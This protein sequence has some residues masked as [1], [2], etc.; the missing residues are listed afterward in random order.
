MKKCPNCGGVV[1]DEA[2]HCQCGH[3]FYVREKPKRAPQSGNTPARARKWDRGLFVIVALFL[4]VTFIRRL[5]PIEEMPR[6]SEIVLG[7]LIDLA[8]AVALVGLGTRI[9]KAIPRGTPGRGGWLSLFVTGLISLLG[10]FVIHLNG[11]QRVEWQPRRPQVTTEALPADLK[12]MTLR[13]EG[14]V[15]SFKKAEA[16]LENTRLVRT[17]NK[18]PDE[19]KKL[20]REDWRD[21]IAKQ[22]AVVDAT[23]EMLEFLTK[24]DFAP[25]FNRV[26]SYAESQGLTGGRKR[27]EIDPRPWRLLRQRYAAEYSLNKKM[28]DHWEEWHSTESS[29]P[30]AKPERWREEVE[31]L[32]ADAKDAQKQLNQLSTPAPSKPTP[33]GH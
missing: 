10:I 4:V 12:D 29:P 2:F 20:S 6:R 32:A 30:N 27:P 9:L 7:I 11:G 5:F 23:D 15:A 22:R 28:E 3:S 31:E 17:V 16:E 19:G 18:N 13:M 8:M 24:P 26:F 25:N 1:S 14:L 33:L 21:C